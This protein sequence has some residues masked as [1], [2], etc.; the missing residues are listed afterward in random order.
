MG[1]IA[2]IVLYIEKHDQL[3]MP[4]FY[5]ELPLTSHLLT[6]SPPPHLKD[7]LHFTR[8]SQHINLSS[9]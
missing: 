5:L 3:L 1:S 7:F 4:Q 6:L 9:I 8:P 2:I